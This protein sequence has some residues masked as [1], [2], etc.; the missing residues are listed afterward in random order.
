[1]VVVRVLVVE[2]VVVMVVGVEAVVG[3]VRYHGWM[4]WRT[5]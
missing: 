1:M 5:I 2:A 3:M 4:I